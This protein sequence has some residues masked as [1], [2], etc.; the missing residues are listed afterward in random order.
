MPEEF[1]E[2]SAEMPD[3][4]EIIGIVRRRRW[5][6][7]VPFFGGWLLVWAA[8]WF[9]PTVYRSG[10]LILVEQPAVP[11]HYVVSNVNDDMQNSLDSITQQILSRTRLLQIIDRS[12]L[13]EKHAGRELSP[14]DKVERMRKDIEI[15][16]V[17]ADDRKLSAFNIYYSSR[18]PEVAQKTTNDLA[19]LFIQQSLQSQTDQ[20][21]ATTKFLTDELEDAR[22][23][24]AEQEERVRVFKDKHLGELPSQLQSNLQ[25]MSSLQTQLQSEQD[26]LG[27]AQQQQT[28]LESLLTQYKAIDRVGKT[29]DGSSIGLAA[30]DKQLDTLRA[31][32]VDLKSRYTDKYPDVRK[33]KEQIAELE[34]TRQQL[35]ASPGSKSSNDSPTAATT[36]ADV[37]DMTPKMELQSQLKANQID[38]ANRQRTLRDLQAQLN[39]YQ[40]RLNSA[41]VR[42]QEFADIT[43]DY[44]QSRANYDSLL[45]KKNQSEMATNLV[46]TQQG[47]RFS[48]LDPPNLPTKPYSPNRLKLAGIGLFVG[49]VLGAGLAGVAEFSDTRLHS[50]REL[51]K[52]VSA[53]VIADIPPLSSPA[54]LAW[55]RRQDWLTAVV[56]AVVL[57][58]MSLGFAI[59]Y[60]HG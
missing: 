41:P 42:E 19:Q 26:A 17:R 4:Q 24:L 39:T 46:K 2:Q 53:N 7:L 1:E 47:Q 51:K 59:T 43:R 36:A 56:A 21:E 22:K 31:Q 33:L 20:S 55:Q 48:M 12:H 29:A 25:I 6:F 35:L 40:A 16:L 15:E 58:C 5:L 9:L 13:Y 34:Q 10:T 32:L 60:L 11:E 3:L 49:L 37:R 38:I 52:L 27:R 44:N 18:D 45:A 57:C 50:E 23:S 14:D 28:Y 30:L 54:E 8:S